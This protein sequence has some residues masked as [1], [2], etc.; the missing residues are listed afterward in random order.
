MAKKLV[1]RLLGTPEV[2]ADKLSVQTFPTKKAL[3]LLLY[4]VTTRTAHDRAEL[5]TLLWENSSERK[6]RTNLRG[7]LKVLRRLVGAHLTIDR[8]RVAFNQESSHRLDLAEFEALAGAGAESGRALLKEISELYRGDFLHGFHLN[9]AS[10][11]EMWML[12]QRARYRE[13]A[14][15]AFY[16]LGEACSARGETDAA[17]SS[18]RKLLSLEPWHEEAHRQLM[19]LLARDGQRG[20]A[21]GQY[22]ICRQVLADELAVEPAGE[23]VALYEQVRDDQLQ[24]ED[25]FSLGENRS[26]T[27]YTC[28]HHLPTALTPL[29]G[30]GRELAQ[31][32]QLLQKSDSRLITILGP[33][34][35]G[36]THLALEVANR[37]VRNFQHGACFVSLTAIDTCSELL[38]ALAGALNFT[39]YRGPSP[40]EQ[41]QHFLHR[42]NMLLVLDNF[43]HLIHEAVLLTDLLGAA[44]ALT[45]LTTSRLRL[46]V[47]GEQIFPLDGLDYPASLTSLPEGGT[48]SSAVQHFVATAQRVQPTFLL[49]ADNRRAVYWICALTQGMPLGILL[50]ASWTALLTPD[51]IA[52]RLTD[53]G[54]TSSEKLDFL[55][56]DSADLDLRQRS[57][58]KVFGYSW[59]L[60]TPEEQAVF[61]Q[62]TVF[63]GGFTL[64]AAEAITGASLTVL[65]AL[66]SKS[67]LRRNAE[68]RFQIHELL[69]QYAAEQLEAD[70][71]KALAV[72]ERHA[73]FYCGL[74]QGLER[75]LRGEPQLEALDNIEDESQN[76][77]AAWRWATQQGRTD[78]LEQAIN[79]LGWFYDWRARFLEGEALFRQTAD[80]LKEVTTDET[81]VMLA[82][83]LTWQAILSRHV[84]P[85]AAVEGLFQE[86]LKILDE[87]RLDTPQFSRARAFLLLRMST[88]LK[89]FDAQTTEDSLTESLTLYRTLSDSWGEAHVLASLG[90]RG[91][92]LGSYRDAKRNLEESLSLFRALCDHNG[93]AH[94]LDTLG[95]IA[96]HEGRLEEAKKL[97]REALDHARN[98]NDR[99]YA[100]ELSARLGITLIW[101]GRFAESIRLFEKSIGLA[102]ELGMKDVLGFAHLGLGNSMLFL[103]KY[104]AARIHSDQSRY[105]RNAMDQTNSMGVVELQ[106]GKIELAMNSCLEAQQRFERGVFLLQE[107][108]SAA[109]LAEALACLGFVAYQAHN[110]ELAGEPLAEALRIAT[111]V[112]AVRPIWYV[113]AATA[114]LSLARGEHE[115]AIE[116]YA[117]AERYPHV[118]NAR[119]FEDVA[120]RHVAA[121]AETLPA[122]VVRRARSRGRTRDLWKTARELASVPVH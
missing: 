31:L 112:G 85:N 95:L 77:R 70:A 17:I 52:E 48:E 11:F 49:T 14:V 118:A 69:R 54:A 98:A 82:R 65:L 103:G 60:M 56:T 111:N 114:L 68:Q 15:D 51:E 37:Q 63:Q 64:A 122:K 33:G 53:E 4:L 72:R 41:L 61:K 110:L 88:N 86:A 23:T 116:L 119:W 45:I 109:L 34:G 120:G 8:Q 30:R 80:R 62:M 57:L 36:K 75:Q 26:G 47:R 46:Q 19:T 83:V 108:R 7:A 35:M 93:A 96:K 20:A 66:I 10:E 100:A 107:S 84:L 115:R 29:I 102:T 99:G 94:V 43:E 79:S 101:A 25:G 55:R 38:S 89:L 121:L 91:W 74:L 9:G 67:L 12:N 76:M 92:Y 2:W 106:A 21:L 13:L 105:F 78:L 97:H 71:T 81:A 16:R 1:L 6:A 22:E 90:E 18:M 27:Q 117:L 44:P 58:R 3:A 28:S 73:A 32:N 87:R 59:R 42:K 113:L 50:A 24:L 104:G 39:F 5:A 40:E